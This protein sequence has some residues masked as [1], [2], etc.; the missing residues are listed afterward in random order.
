LPSL[1]RHPDPTMDKLSDILK[2]TDKETAEKLV[3]LTIARLQKTCGYA[4][5]SGFENRI[6]LDLQSDMG[7]A[8]TVILD[9][10]DEYYGS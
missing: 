10:I 8:G 5:G 2:E 7:R 9:E 1:H 3:R 6:R 4:I